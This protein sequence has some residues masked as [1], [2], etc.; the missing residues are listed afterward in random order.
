MADTMRV[1]AERY[2]NVTKELVKIQMKIAEKRE[3]GEEKV[4]ERIKAMSEDELMKVCE[5]LITSLEE[6]SLKAKELLEELTIIEK[7]YRGA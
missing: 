4:P 1:L 6:K 2:S 5:A 7:E 3:G